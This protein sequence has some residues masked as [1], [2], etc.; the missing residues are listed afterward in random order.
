[1][2]RNKDAGPQVTLTVPDDQPQ[3]Q[4]EQTG[5]PRV[6]ALNATIAGN[7]VDHS[8]PAEEDG[9]A[10]ERPSEADGDEQPA[11]PQA[12]TLTDRLLALEGEAPEGQPAQTEWERPP[13]HRLVMVGDDA[14]TTRYPP[15]KIGDMVL[16]HGKKPFPPLFVK[17]DHPAIVTAVQPAAGEGDYPVLWL[18]VFLPNRIE[19]TGLVSY[20][21]GPGQWS[22]LDYPTLPF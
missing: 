10:A 11:E 20:G 19:S 7:H 18:A 14:I 21:H 12:Y 3:A 16:Y 4:P 8:P 22:H 9:D 2:A 6:D 13:V 5:I 17:A 1:M 15:I